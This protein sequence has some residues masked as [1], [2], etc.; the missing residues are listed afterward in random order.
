MRWIC[1][2]LVAGLVVIG[3]AACQSDGRAEGA[4]TSQGAPRDWPSVTKGPLSPSATS[5]DSA[6]A[7]SST[8][9]PE[10]ASSTDQASLAGGTATP[11]PSLLPTKVR[12][13]PTP[14]LVP[15]ESPPIRLVIP[16]IQ[17]DAPI[18]PIGWHQAR[19]SQATAWDDPGSAAGWL[20]SSAL[21]GR[22]S[23]VVLAGHHNIR[24]EVFGRLIDLRIGDRVYLTGDG[25]TYAYRVREHFIIPEK[26]APPEQREQNGLWIGPTVDERLTLVTC[27]PHRDNTHRLIVVARPDAG[28]LAEGVSST[29]PPACAQG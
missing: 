14:T 2:L 24:G 25:L 23:N 26:H 17:L 8:I 4:A 19:D 22:G 27:W 12:P 21:P 16:S 18:V 9:A 15:A 13:M 7:P 10:S 29:P 11:S 6:W 5:V 1:V 28:T 3:L 20:K